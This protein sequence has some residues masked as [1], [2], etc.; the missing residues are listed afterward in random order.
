[1]QKLMS[2]EYA[3]EYPC[4]MRR[5]HG[6][7]KM[8]ALG[9]KAALVSRIVNQT[10]ETERSPSTESIEFTASLSEDVERAEEI[11]AYCRENCPAHLPQELEGSAK[12]ER[13]PALGE[14]EPIG[15]LGRIRYPIQA[16][17]EKFVA[18]RVQS[19]ADSTPIE[20]WPGLLRI[21]LA[22]ESPFDGELTKELRR[23]TTDENLRFF[24]RRL[25][26]SLTGSAARLTTDHIFDLF[27][28]F[29]STDE[30][31][32]GYQR[33]LPFEALGDFQEFLEMILIHNLPATEIS[34]LHRSDTSYAQ[35]LRLNHAIARAR[36]LGVRLLMD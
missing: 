30:G 7:P 3:I 6:D 8:R 23:I 27:S 29:L 2:L 16:G 22:P 25:P 13:L 19:I 31:I 28:G 17:F 1:M 15:C 32:S 10:L 26:V 34:R 21:L 24:E 11:A 5:R 9:R 20:E 4:E 35:F 36:S 12:D 14:R 33:E 18:E